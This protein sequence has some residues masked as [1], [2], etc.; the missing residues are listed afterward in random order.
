MASVT[1]TMVS[2]ALVVLLIVDDFVVF[3]AWKY[4]IEL[5]LVVNNRINE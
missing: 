4:D 2:L 1:F 3:E 5:R